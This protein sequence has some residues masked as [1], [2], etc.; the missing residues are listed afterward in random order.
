MRLS[1]EDVPEE[2]LPAL[3]RSARVVV[4][5][6]VR[7]RSGDMDGLPRILIEAMAVGVPVVSTR[8]AGIPDLVREG[9]DGLLVKPHHIEALAES[10]GE[11][12]HELGRAEALG[13]RAVARSR[14]YF[15]REES[16]RRL[17]RLFQ[18]AASHPGPSPP[19]PDLR[20]PPAPGSSAEYEPGMREPLTQLV[21][22]RRE[23]SRP[24]VRHV[25]RG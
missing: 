25:E 20:F 8:L 3:L 4:L 12:L 1:G 16:T 17:A 19:D 23:V 11:M 2:E 7:D 13:S 15:G 10:L 9:R 21:R 6:C 24:V 5:P 22:P 14:A 18:W